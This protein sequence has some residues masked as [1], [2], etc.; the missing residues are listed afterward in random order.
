[1]S[2][3]RVGETVYNTLKGTGPEKRAGETKI[4]KRRGKPGH[5]GGALKKGGWNP[6]T[7]YDIIS[8]DIDV[9]FE[10]IFL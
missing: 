2:C 9:A 6:L 1:M 5:G 3:A 8:R 10:L 7:S 4:L